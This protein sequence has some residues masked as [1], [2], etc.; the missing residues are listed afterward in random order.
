MIEQRCRDADPG[1]VGSGHHPGRR[2]ARAT[3]RC[4]QPGPAA[5]LDHHGA[6]VCDTVQDLLAAAV[7]A[8]GEVPVLLER[9]TNLPPLAEVLDEA[10]A[11]RARIAA[12][13]ERGAA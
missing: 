5:L 3:D 7:A 2:L 11:L 6:P 4:D 9:D 12:G 8:I 13:A 1:R 10:D